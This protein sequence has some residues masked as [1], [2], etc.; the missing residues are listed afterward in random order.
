MSF[1]T[2]MRF[3][4]E[5]WSKT[6]KIMHLFNSFVSSFESFLGICWQ[7]VIGCR[8]ESVL[9]SFFIRETAQ[10]EEAVWVVKRSISTSQMEESCS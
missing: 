10:K 2:V 1:F 3:L 4:L 7:G 8:E 9:G 6:A 5:L